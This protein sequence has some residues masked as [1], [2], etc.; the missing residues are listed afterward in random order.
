MLSMIAW[1]VR[2]VS[3]SSLGGSFVWF[4]VEDGEV[5]TGVHLTPARRM[6]EREATLIMLATSSCSGSFILTHAEPRMNAIVVLANWGPAA[7]MNL[8]V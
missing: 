5:E 1:I 4:W 7:L 8:E 3:L 2:W 6:K